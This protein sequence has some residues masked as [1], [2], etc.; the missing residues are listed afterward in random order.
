MKVPYGASLQYVDALTAGLLHNAQLCLFKNNY[1]PVDATV[2]GDLTE[3][4]FDGYARITLSTWSAAALDGSNK[5]SSA[6]AS[7]TFTMSAPAA[8]PNTIYGIYVLTAGGALLYAERN[9]A[10]GIT[11][12]TAGQTYSYLPRFT[13]KSEF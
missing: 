4:D 5:A 8:T 12:N 1:S 9:P 13:G 2:L 6:I 10:G 11:M 7:Q 3:A